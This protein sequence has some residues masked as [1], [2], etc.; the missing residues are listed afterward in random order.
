[1]AQTIQ[2]RG[3][4]LRDAVL[5]ELSN[6]GMRAWIDYNDYDTI[7]WSTSRD[8]E[9]SEKISS[10]ERLKAGLDKIERF[11]TDP[12]KE[13]EK[14]D[15]AGA[16]KALAN[17]YLAEIRNLLKDNFEDILSETLSNKNKSKKLGG[18][19]L[20]D[21]ETMFFWLQSNKVLSQNREAVLDLGRFYDQANETYIG[22]S[23]IYKD[24]LKNRGF[25]G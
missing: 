6:L 4:Y 14:Y 15:E 17:R 25:F 3:Q 12:D 2:G 1:M 16:D 18:G 7:F 8:D 5:A 10:V 22:T 13:F 11:F 9:T 23:Q 24:F 19:N 21:D 20:D